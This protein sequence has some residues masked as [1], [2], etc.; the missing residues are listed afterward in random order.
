MR[1]ARVIV[2]TSVIAS[3]G[4]ATAVAMR[5]H[6][7]VAASPRW[8]VAGERSRRDADIAWYTMR[9]ERDPTGAF[10]RLRLAALYLQR[11]RERGSPGDL[12]LAE[13]E[14]RRSLVNRRAHNSEAFR[15]LAIALIGQHR[16]AEAADATDSLLTAD[17]S[18]HGAQSLR[19]EIALEQGDYPLADRLF[20]PLDH[21]G[22]D[23]AVTARVARWAAM[24][25][26]AGHAKAL[27]EQA[28]E[29]A[30]RMAFTP[31]EQIAW[32]DL[33]LGDLARTVGATRLAARALNAAAAVAPDDARVLTTQAQ[34]ALDTN[35]PADALE[36]A[37]AAMAHGGDPLALALAAEAMR[38]LGRDQEA[39]QRFRAFETLIAGV[40][41]TAWHRQWR[42]AL[43]DRGRQ[44]PA[45]LAQAE[46]ELLTRKDVLGYDVYAWALHKA[47]RTDEARQAMHQA[48][49]WGTEDRLLDA[50]AKALGMTR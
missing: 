32:Y 41:G 37:E 5:G 31:A 40:P 47:G 12:L 30:R 29:D 1:W 19:A 26:R 46:A 49:R 4:V 48:L 17:P 14:A 50:H 11:A 34:L 7:R 13:Q 8:D 15:V 21:G 9:A 22:E 24:R 28:R 20:T 16:F 27:L 33:R 36:Y 18:S 10:D 39:E 2:I 43:L 23:P 35:D 45:V 38:R 44:V 25:G 42:L 6:T 3:F